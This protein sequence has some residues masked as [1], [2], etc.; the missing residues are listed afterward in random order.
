[1]WQGCSRRP[2]ARA[3]VR[4]LLAL[5]GLLFSRPSWAAEP[6]VLTETDSEPGVVVY[7]ATSPGAHRVTVLLHGMCGEPA[8]ACRRV[9]GST[10]E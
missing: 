1:M 9:F 2:G 7:P 4:R 8:N 3:K 6:L 5:L 10:T